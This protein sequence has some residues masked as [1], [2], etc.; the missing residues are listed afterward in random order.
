MNKPMDDKKEEIIEEEP[1]IDESLLTPEQ[2]EE[3]AKPFFKWQY[4]VVW[5]VLIAAIIACIVV[6]L[7][8]R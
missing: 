2:K 4:L 3:M 1:E 7:V 5:G 6:L 8:L